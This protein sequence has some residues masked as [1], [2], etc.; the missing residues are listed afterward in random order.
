M[1]SIVCEGDPTDHGGY[2]LQATSTYYINGKKAAL[3]GDLVWCPEHEANPIVE[4]DDT[5]FSDG[6]RVVVEG[7]RSACGSRIIAISREVSVS[8]EFQRS[9]FEQSTVTE[10]THSVTSS[11]PTFPLPIHTPSETCHH[12]DDNDAVR[13]AQ[14]TV[15]Q[16]IENS[17]GDLVKYIIENNSYD[18]VKD[19]EA[20][21]AR[22]WY[23]KLGG[24]PDY[25]EI[26]IQKK[27]AARL[28][29]ARKVRQNGDWDFKPIIDID[30]K[31]HNELPEKYRKY[32]LSRSF[33]RPQ[34]PEVGADGK[35]HSGVYHQ[36][37]GYDYSHD[38]WGNIHYGY[39][40][41]AAGFSEEELLK[42]GGIAQ[43]IDD[44]VGVLWRD[45]THLKQPLKLPHVQNHP[46]NG[47]FPKSADDSQ[48]QCS[49]KVGLELFKRYPPD[50]LT[51]QALLN[52]I[53]SV[54]VQAWAPKG[55]LL[56]A[57]V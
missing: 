42:A 13:V 38:I 30:P 33:T 40:G 54:S 9:S 44:T 24:M 46:K 22:S 16:M 57:C 50:Q 17:Q 51:V 1:R 6:K 12:H 11:S 19:I 15:D 41:R 5:F 4:A 56:H 47:E 52:K 18:S 7:C 10:S 25:S 23:E 2:V 32:H 53:E 20:W 43:I 36:Y 27:I 28:A 8:E 48:D 14:F 49:I 3:M 21:Q 35:K 45:V 29:W 55:K 26:E 37:K 39:V 31:K 34:F